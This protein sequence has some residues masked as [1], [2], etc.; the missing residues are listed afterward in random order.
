M[1]CR[2]KCESAPF[3]PPRMS[4]RSQDDASQLLSLLCKTLIDAVC[5]AR[6]H[7]VNCGDDRYDA[8]GTNDNYP[9]ACRR[10]LFALQKGR[11]G[12]SVERKRAKDDLQGSIDSRLMQV[13]MNLGESKC[14]RTVQWL[15]HR[16]TRPP[17]VSNA[18]APKPSSA[19]APGSGTVTEK[20]SNCATKDWIWP[21]CVR[22]GFAACTPK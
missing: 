6:S 12:Q 13:A 3:V 16:F 15:I 7:R 2:K 17:T 5:A 20:L 8:K 18:T 11:N 19:S 4:W 21:V 22:P 9:S 1:S 10:F 14:I